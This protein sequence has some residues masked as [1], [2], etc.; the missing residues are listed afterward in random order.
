MKKDQKS[1]EINDNQV[2]KDSWTLENALQILQNPTVD[3]KLWAEAVE[4]LMLY[5]PEP[6]RQ[7]LLSASMH[8]TQKQFPNLK[9]AGCTNE[10]DVCYNIEDI[11]QALNIDIDEARRIIEKKEKS[12]NI[13]HGFSDIDTNKV[14]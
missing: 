14:Q 2:F 11:A 13:R 7:H 1:K 5:G 8:A 4:W 6:I 9:S 12:H 10:G 3:S